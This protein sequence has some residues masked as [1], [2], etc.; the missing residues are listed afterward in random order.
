M[1]TPW[2]CGGHQR[3]RHDRRLGPPALRVL[4]R[5]SSR[6]STSA[7]INRVAYDI[8][9][10][11]RPPSS[12]SRRPAASRLGREGAGEGRGYM[13]APGDGLAPPAE[14]FG[15][16]S[17]SSRCGGGGSSRGEGE[18]AKERPG[19][20]LGQARDGS[21]C[22]SPDR[23]RRYPSQPVL[24]AEGETCPSPTTPNCAPCSV[25]RSP[26][27]RDAWPRSARLR[28]GEIDP[29]L[30][31]ELY[32]EGHTVKG[33]A[34]MM[35]FTA[36]ADAGKLLEEVWKG[37]QE[38]ELTMTSALGE[39]LRAWP[40]ASRRR[41]RQTPPPAHPPREAVRAVRGAS[42]AGSSTTRPGSSGD[43]PAGAG[44]PGRTA[45]LHRLVAFGRTSG[46]TRPNCSVSSTRCAHCGSMREPCR[47]GGRVDR[48]AG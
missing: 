7:G 28:G 37:V 20:G 1:P 31:G 33:T 16:R 8:S 11:P 41:S 17:S 35:G 27:G 22:S 42:T 36:I 45:R 46:S 13:D 38:S 29:A 12:G 44:R 5:I 30:A 21:A 15:T 9:S 25:P 4:E 14:P 24:I 2:S 39:A 26:S 43:R 48:L 47:R 23:A 10:K 3:R 18:S 32:R 6:S 19:S 40:P 34:R